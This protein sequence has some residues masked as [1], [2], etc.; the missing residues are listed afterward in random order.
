[1]K[2][3]RFSLLENENSTA[4]KAQ[5]SSYEKEDKPHF[6]LLTKETEKAPEKIPFSRKLHYWLIENKA[7]FLHRTYGLKINYN[8]KKTIQYLLEVKCTGYKKGIFYYTLD[9]TRF[10]KDGKQ[11]DRF[12]EQLAEQSVSCLY[13]LKV[14]VNKLGEIVSVTN[15][16]EIEKRWQI[17]QK[18]LAKRYKG[19]PFIN[20]CQKIS[21][22]VSSSAK[23]LE[24]LRNDVV[25]DILFSKLYINYSNKFTKPLEKEFK[26]F[27]GFKKVQFYGSQTVNPII[28][29]NKRILINYNGV[30]RPIGGLGTGETLVK[31]ELDSKDNSLLRVDGLFNYTQNNVNETIEF[32]AIWQKSMD[33]TIAQQ[34]AYEKRKGIYFD[35]DAEKKWYE[36]WK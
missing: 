23:L 31:Y 15:Q 35:P 33:K 27:S 2:D 13:P 24:S 28:K 16:E 21:N 22:S 26:W 1:M 6:S 7:T 8:N 10:F 9:R 18:E 12:M 34:I 14:S 36:F 3:K 4:L 30:M 20:Y 5:G 29:E 25:Y 32:K 19:N 11:L 17:K